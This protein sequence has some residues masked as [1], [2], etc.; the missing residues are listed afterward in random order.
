MSGVTVKE[1]LTDKVCVFRD[2]EHAGVV[3]A[4]ILGTYRSSDAVVLGIPAGG[5]PVAAEVARHLGL[6]LDVVVVSNG[7]QD[8]W[9]NDG[10]GSFTIATLGGGNSQDVA[11]GDLDGDG[12][13]DAVVANFSGQSQAIWTNDGSGSFTVATTRP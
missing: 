5:V 8:I 3:L 4:D 6:H 10:A 1:E 9:S 7:P 13:L 12:D 11:L 2:R